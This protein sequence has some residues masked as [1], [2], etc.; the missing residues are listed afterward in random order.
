[1]GTLIQ[2]LT[3]PTSAAPARAA[4]DPALQVSLIALSST[5][6]RLL[7]GSISDYLAPPAPLHHLP[8]LPPPSKRFHCSRIVIMFIFSAI[9]F[10]GFLLVATGAVHARPDLFWLVSSSIGAG[11]GAVFCLAPTVVSVVWGTRNFG[12]NWG[13]VTMT[14]ALGAVVYGCL[15]AVEY[16]AGTGVGGVCY[17]GGCVER[18]FAVMSGSVVAAVVGWGWVWGKW[19]RERVAV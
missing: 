7:A 12:T 8:P 4:V 1:M 17:G 10:M 13:I 11:Y 9:M 15:F 14:P 2:T 16:D 18:S 5:L 3:P 19:K 6:A